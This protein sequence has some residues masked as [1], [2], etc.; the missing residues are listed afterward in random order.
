MY[1]LNPEQ[2]KVV[3]RAKEIAAQQIAPYAS[4]VDSEGRFP[5]EAINA[6]AEE[7]FLG[8]TVPSEFG[9]MGQGIRVACA[10]LEEIARQCPSTAMI[11]MMHLCGIAMYQA[12]P[13]NTKEQLR[14]AATGK[15]L[16]T[17]AWSE[18]GSRSNFWAPVSQEKRHSGVIEINAQKSFV[19]S[20]GHADGYVV[21]TRWENAAS[22]IETM[23]YL[24]LK[25][26]AGV[27][28]EGKWDALG[29]RGNAS[30]PINLE[31]VRIDSSRALSEEG[32]G[33]DAMLGVVL[34]VF[35]LSG[36]SIAIGIAEA[37]VQATQTHLTSTRLE[38]QGSKLAELPNLRA[39]LAKM[40][41]ETD[42]ARAHL[43]SVIHAVENQQPEAQLLLLEIRASASE[44][45][46]D[47]TDMAMRACG[48]AA[49]SKKLGIE[50]YFRDARASIIMA[51]TPDHVLDFIGKTLCGMEVFA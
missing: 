36:A 41:I 5:I 37:S 26:D 1:Q 30:A 22:P 40:R 50:R 34:P 51:P 9:G 47:V 32:K 11:Y 49:F 14:A 12:Y 33:L 7:G 28:V 35:Q 15:H 16:S 46:V 19:T 3:E 42:R 4:Q 43:V 31:R 44:T 21:S 17:L 25:Q 23:L 13:Q 10:V 48:G 24:I 39:T 6:L 8:L 20:A 27:T 38:H 45:A 2:R 29:L 18:K